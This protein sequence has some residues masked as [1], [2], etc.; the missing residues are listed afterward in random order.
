MRRWTAGEV[1][2]MAVAAV[3]RLRALAVDGVAPTKPVYD[4]QRGSGAPSSAV[5]FRHG[6]K[7]QELLRRAGL[8]GA[9]RGYNTP[10][11]VAKRN[12]DRLAPGVPNAVEMEIRAAFERGDH[13]PAVRRE[14]PL[15]AIPTRLEVREWPL[16]DGSGVMRVTRAYASL[17]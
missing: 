8:S 10:A 12:G 4:A 5:L 11:A 1:E 13:V 17:R 2:E 16:A 15:F 6:V 7:W 9:L 14:W 3:A